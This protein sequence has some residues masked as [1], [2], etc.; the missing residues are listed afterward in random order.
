MQRII[1]GPPRQT[2]LRQLSRPTT[3]PTRF[4]MRGLHGDQ[5]HPSL[6]SQQLKSLNDE[7]RRIHSDVD[8][9]TAQLSVR[10]SALDTSLKAT[11]DKISAQLDSLSEAIDKARLKIPGNRPLSD[12]MSDIANSVALDIR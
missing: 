1:R 2:I 8:Q 10:L 11:D 12:A 7:M 3:Y 9:Q 5:S 4:P 6:L